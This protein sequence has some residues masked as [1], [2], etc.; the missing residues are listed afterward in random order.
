MYVFVKD[1]YNSFIM[2]YLVVFTY[3]ENEDIPAILYTNFLDSSYIDV[4]TL[5]CF[6]VVLE[7]TLLQGFVIKVG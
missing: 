6:K 2:L 5:N 3:C 7:N 1:G 4:F